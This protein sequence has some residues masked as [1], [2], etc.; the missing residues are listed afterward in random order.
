[1]TVSSLVPLVVGV[2]SDNEGYLNAKRDRMGHRL[3]DSITSA[4]VFAKLEGKA[5]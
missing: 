5:A 1:M 3:P 2:G 4:P